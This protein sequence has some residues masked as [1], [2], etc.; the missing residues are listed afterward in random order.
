MITVVASLFPILLCLAGGWLLA[1]VL[2]AGLRTRLTRLIPPFIWLLLF[3]IGY[4]YGNVLSSLREAG[5]SAANALV[6]ALMT[7]VVP[8]LMLSVGSHRE[9]QDESGARAQG[10]AGLAHP[11]KECLVAFAMLALGVAVYVVWGTA[12][13]AHVWWPS[14]SGLLYA[15]IVLVGLDLYGVKPDPS[16]YSL[17]TLKIPLFVVLGSL[18]GG[19]LASWLTGQALGVGLALSS[20]FGWFT[21]SSV[22]VGRHAGEALGVVALLTDLFRELLAIA[23]LYCLGARRPQ[24]CIAAGGA[25]A[26]DSTLP[27]IKQTCHAANLPVALVSGFILTLFAPF[28]MVLFLTS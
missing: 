17:R 19:A 11:I 26:L 2:R 12:P 1:F 15:L 25:T 16:W 14:T 27:I 13:A 28:L 5:G 21:L 9:K 6:F 7:T 10:L 3:S 23:L 18:L 4:E 20:G 8:W 22:L 24:Q